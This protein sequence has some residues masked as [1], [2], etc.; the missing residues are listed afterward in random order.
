MTRPRRFAKAALAL[1][2]AVIPTVAVPVAATAASAAVIQ[3]PQPVGAFPPQVGRACRIWASLGW[4]ARQAPVD[5][6]IYGPEYIRGSS[7]YGNRGGDLPAGG[8]Y[9]EYDVNTRPAPTA[10]R[11]AERLVRDESTSRVWYSAGHDANFREIS[12]GC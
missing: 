3:P 1:A 9:H 5:Y 12:G 7:P 2:L 11:D 10:S 8:D 4:P 6:R